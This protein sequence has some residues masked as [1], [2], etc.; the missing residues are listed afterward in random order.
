M[1]R[2][3]K[4]NK[5]FGRFKTPE[6]TERQ[7]QE[8]RRRRR[9]DYIMRFG[10]PTPKDIRPREIPSGEPILKPL[11]LPVVHSSPFDFIAGILT[12][13][14]WIRRRRA[15]AALQDQRS[16]SIKAQGRWLKGSGIG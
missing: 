10:M 12:L 6:L 14:P 15:R 13:M 16:E 2:S 11:P 8:R 1:G 4:F 5:K 3:V 9:M 7:T